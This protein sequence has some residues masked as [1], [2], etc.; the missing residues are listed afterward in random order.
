MISEIITFLLGCLMGWFTN[1]WYAVV[2]KQPSLVRSGGGS[3]S[4][5]F[6]S[7]YYY[8]SLTIQNE[9][10]RLG[11]SFPETVIL[12]KTIKT[13]FGG[14]L[15]E[16]DPAVDCRAQLLETSEQPICHLWWLDGQKVT[17][18]VDIKSGESVH[19]IVFLRRE[20]DSTYFA[21]QPT[22]GTDPTSKTSSVVLSTN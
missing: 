20:N 13:D 18:A 7:G 22:S 2:M 8:V 17:E 10:R 4:S 3:G 12:G 6:G 5:L 21:Y 14:R 11:I 9:L 1:H 19:L 16:R 15:I